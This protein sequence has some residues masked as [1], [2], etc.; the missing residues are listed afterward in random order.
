MGQPSLSFR[1]GAKTPLAGDP[2]P[3]IALFVMVGPLVHKLNAPAR[4]RLDGI[5]GKRVGRRSRGHNQNPIQARRGETVGRPEENITP[6]DGPPS[7]VRFGVLGMTALM[8]V[9]LY[10]DRVC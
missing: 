9:L 6:F 4:P 2:S 1:R 7:R 5:P 10:L 3:P 8:A